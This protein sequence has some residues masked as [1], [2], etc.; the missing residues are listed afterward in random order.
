M[1][2][3]YPK[4]P[5]FPQLTRDVVIDYIVENFPQRYKRENFNHTKTAIKVWSLNRL[6]NEYHELVKCDGLPKGEW[7]RRQ[8]TT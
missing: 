4:L 3:T 7:L 5:S 6:V 1:N 8:E 2:T